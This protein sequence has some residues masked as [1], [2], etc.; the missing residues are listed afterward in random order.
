MPSSG[1]G[2]STATSSHLGHRQ[3]PPAP[4]AVVVDRFAVRDRD[5]PAAQIAAVLQLRIGAQGGDEG[6]LEA[7]VGVAAPD[8]A[9]AYGHHLVRVLVDQGLE[10][11]QLSHLVD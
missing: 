7:V 11:G 1:S 6:L 4:G 3:R 9:A 5:Q 10:R 8:R 2:S